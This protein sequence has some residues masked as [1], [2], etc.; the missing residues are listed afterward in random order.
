VRR[1]FKCR[2]EV[3]EVLKKNYTK[4]V[5]DKYE[6]LIFCIHLKLVVYFGF[7]LVR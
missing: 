3:F 5:E 2:K 6:G 7:S 4:I 1:G